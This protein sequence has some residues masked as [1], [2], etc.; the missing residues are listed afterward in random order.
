MKQLEDGF[1][2][3]YSLKGSSPFR[4]GGHSDRQ[5]YGSESLLIFSEPGS[6]DLK[7]EVE[8]AYNF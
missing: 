3:A 8:P 5:L 1:C 2:L 7:P 6:E 4:Q